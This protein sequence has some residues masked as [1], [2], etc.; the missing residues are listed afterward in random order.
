MKSGTPL[1]IK[2]FGNIWRKLTFENFMWGLVHL[3]RKGCWVWDKHRVCVP[4]TVTL[5]NVWSPL[6]NVC[7]QFILNCASHCFFSVSRFKFCQLVLSLWTN[8]ILCLIT[9]DE[10]K[11]I[12]N[13][14]PIKMFGLEI[15]QIF[16]HGTYTYVTNLHVL[17][18][19]PST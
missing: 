2:E 3:K 6:P 8:R 13:K 5:V 11:P 9:Y 19:Y 10:F 15:Y 14:I 16:H 18:M 7:L 12:N 1:W 17:H 4:D